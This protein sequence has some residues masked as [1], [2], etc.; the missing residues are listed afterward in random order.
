MC[1]VCHTRPSDPCPSHV[2][3]PGQLLGRD[4]LPPTPPPHPTPP[5]PP[6]QLLRRAALEE[7]V[8]A[9]APALA[10]LSLG[11]HRGGGD[12]SARG[13][14]KCQPEGR[15]GGYISLSEWSLV[16]YEGEG[17]GGEGCAGLGWLGHP[18]PCTCRYQGSPPHTLSPCSL[19]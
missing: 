18:N 4:P 10:D 3:P 13:W 8:K 5:L 11:R 1:D 2:A 19:M 7:P 14:G 12:M 17:V 15:G 6:G 9:E 16:I